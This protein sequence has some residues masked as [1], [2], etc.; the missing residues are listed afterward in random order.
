MKEEKKRKMERIKKHAHPVHVFLPFPTLCAFPVLTRRARSNLCRAQKHRRDHKRLHM[1]LFP[2]IRG[3][4]T[5]QK[6]RLKIDG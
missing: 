3:R 1:F 5:T 2:G 4:A 6:V